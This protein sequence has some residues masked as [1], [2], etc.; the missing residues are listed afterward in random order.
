M[1]ESALPQEVPWTLSANGTRLA[2]GASSPGDWAALLAGWL[3]SE[4]AVVRRADL[5]SVR[6]ELLESGAVHVAADVDAAGLQRAT[7][8]QRHRQEAGCGLHHFLHC[9]PGLLRRAR[10]PLAPTADEAADLLKAVFAACNAASPAGGIHGAALSSGPTLNAPSIDVA[11]HSAVLR[12]IGAAFLDG[13]DLSV[14]GLVLTARVSG[15]IAATAARA[16]LAW[17]A[18]RSIPTTLAAAIAANAGLPI[19]ARAGSRGAER[20]GA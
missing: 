9:A 12:A 15:P 1:S 17:V 18:S 13:A 19:L 8:E 11:R 16:G 4:G 6:W 20:M 7:E 14:L 3:V 10:A 2:T 5:R